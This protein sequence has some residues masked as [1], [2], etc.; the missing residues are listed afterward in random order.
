LKQTE[1]RP[2]GAQGAGREGGFTLI[3]T[4][5]ALLILMIAALSI[6]SLFTYAIQYNTGA[7]DRALAQ[8]IAQRQME[9]LRKTP[10]NQVASSTATVTSGG[11]T[12]N[13]V[14]TAC[15]GSARMMRITVQVTPQGAGPSWSRSSVTLIALRGVTYF[16]SYY[17]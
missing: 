11:R 17:Q 6:A 1:R 2:E 3:E 9:Y 8:A 5:I 15:G 14:T 12:F 13:V 7:N 4:S 16:G 10:F